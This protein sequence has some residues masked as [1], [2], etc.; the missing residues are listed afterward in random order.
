MSL[1]KG[2]VSLTRY[3]VMDQPPD[4]TDDFLAEHLRN[5]AFMDIEGTTEEESIG[6]VEVLDP[7]QI[8]FDPISFRFGPAVAMALRVDARKLSAK[9]VNRY[10]ALAEMQAEAAGQK[11]RTLDERRTLKLKV[12]QDL[13]M[14]TPVTTDVYEVVWMPGE[15]EVWLAAVSSKMRER[16]EDLWRQTFKMGLLMKIP[17][18]LAQQNLPKGTTPKDLDRLKPHAWMSGR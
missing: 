12:R 6:W 15:A 17:W 5:N 16:F 7:L 8:N 3:T 11:P 10:Y 1:I 13:L 9:T 4:V 18:V 2:S 14:R